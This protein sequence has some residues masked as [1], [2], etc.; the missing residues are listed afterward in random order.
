MKPSALPESESLPTAA[1]VYRF[2]DEAGALLY[3][4]KA[5]NLR[6][7]LSQYRNAKRRKAHY[8][9]RRIVA[10]ASRLSWEI[11]PTELDALLL[12]TEL[13]QKLR[14]TFNA[15]GAFSFLYPYVGIRREGTALR[16]CLTTHPESFDRFRLFGCYR[17]RDRTQE[18]FYAW[19]E[20]L[21]YLGHVT[22]RGRKRNLS[23]V[24]HSFEAEVRSLPP[25]VLQAEWEAALEGR[26]PGALQSL[27]VALL[28]SSAA[29]REAEEVQGHLRALARFYRTEAVKLRRMLNRVEG[30]SF[31]VAQRERDPLLHRYRATFNPS[32][33]GVG[34]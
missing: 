29:C 7:R 26:S 23:D 25:T 2:F 4:G 34:A 16:I 33:A 22:K 24:P 17:S 30:V 19:L 5:K 1:G 11:C 3:V 21:T 15:A 8:K 27:S 6:R 20:L 32:R 10:A 28:E 31:P 12:E 14:P 9:M 18:G 13:I